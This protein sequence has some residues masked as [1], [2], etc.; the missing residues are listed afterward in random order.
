[1]QGM[2]ECR[3]SDRACELVKATGLYLYSC[4]VWQSVWGCQNIETSDY[5]V[6]VE[7]PVNG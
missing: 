2:V 7:L 4:V 5:C 1:M 6:T 3:V